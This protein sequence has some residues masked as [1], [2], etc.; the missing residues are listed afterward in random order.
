MRRISE[1]HAILMKTMK[2]LSA[3]IKKIERKME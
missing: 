3:S 2:D 1:E